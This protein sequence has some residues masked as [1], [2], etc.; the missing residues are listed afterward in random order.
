MG[1]SGMTP[2]VGGQSVL[3]VAAHPDDEVLGCGG[4]IARHGREGDSV[5]VVIMA[6]G[7]TSRG[8]PDAGDR[9]ALAAAARAASEALGVASLDFVNFPDNRMDGV[10]LLDITREIERHIDAVDPCIVYSHHGGD[11]NIDHQRTHQAVVTACRPLPGRRV[12]ELLFFE[13]PSSTEW[14]TPG[15]ASSFAPNHW[16]DISRDMERKTEA[17]RCY[18]S[19]MRPWPHPRSYDA[20]RRLNL[21]RGAAVGVEAAEAFMIGRSIRF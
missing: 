15:S 6:E 20:V 10:D 3:V 16:V 7:L 9:T 1:T 5:H 21:L 17:L 2:G 13:T 18:E 12:R 8:E 19:E 4:T 14:Q 11:V